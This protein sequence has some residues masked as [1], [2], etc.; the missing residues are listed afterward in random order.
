L[1][2]KNEEKMG[3]S[4]GL[5]AGSLTVFQNHNALYEQHQRRPGNRVSIALGGALG[6]GE[7]PFLQ[8][9]IVEH[10]A[11]F[12]PVKQLDGVFLGADEDKHLSGNGISA[13]LASHQTTE[14]IET[15]AHIGGL[16]KEKKAMG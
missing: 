8:T 12:L 10:K 5:V 15:L 3:L 1:K 11:P 16:T 14:S 6:E 7:G 4:G 13:H 9:L 2:K